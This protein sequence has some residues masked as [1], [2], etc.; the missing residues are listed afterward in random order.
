MLFVGKFP[1][2]GARCI[3]AV[4][5]KIA[6]R[7]ATLIV[8]ATPRPGKDAAG[9]VAAKQIEVAQL[10]TGSWPRGRIERRSEHLAVTGTPAAALASSKSNVN[11]GVAK[12]QRVS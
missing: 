12:V 9:T 3:A 11:V 4:V 7:E 8:V 1:E 5:D 10:L 2:E 6:I